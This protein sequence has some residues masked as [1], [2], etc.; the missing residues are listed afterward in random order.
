MVF[1]YEKCFKQINTGNKAEKKFGYHNE[2]K[3]GASCLLEK[4]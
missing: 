1:W 2:E 4:L 3:G